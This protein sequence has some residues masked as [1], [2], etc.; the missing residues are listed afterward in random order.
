MTKKLYE[1]NKERAGFEISS[2]KKGLK[3][4]YWTADW[5]TKD[6]ILYVEETKRFNRNTDFSV[7]WNEIYTYGELFAEWLYEAL[8]N[9]EETKFNIYR[10]V[11][12]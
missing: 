2:T 1:N 10:I 4:E 11:K 3:V 5:D 6:Y 9:K 8:S 7:E 12:N